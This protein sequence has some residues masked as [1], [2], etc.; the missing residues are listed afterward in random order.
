M[1]LAFKDENDYNWVVRKICVIGPGI[2][3]M[4]MAALLANARI[5]QGSDSP[6]KVLVLQRASRTSG[7]KVDAINSGKSVIGGVEPGLDAIVANCVKEGLLSATSNPVDAADSDVVLVCVQTD[8]K[9][10]EPDYG[11]LFDAL[12]HLAGALQKRPAGNIPVI[13]FESTLAPSTMESVIRPF[14]AERGLVE[15]KDIL[16][17]NSPNRVMPG[18]LVERVASA[19][20]LV[21]GLHPLTAKLVA[22]LYSHIVTKGTL[23]QTNSMTA[24]VVKTLENAYRDVRIAFASEIVR[25]C[26][27]NDIDFFAVRDAV[28]ER[29]QQTDAASKDATAVPVGG[30]LVPLVGVGGHC[31]PKDGILLWWRKIESKADTGRSLILE[32]RKINDAAPAETIAL[33]ERAFGPVD[34]KRVALLGTAYRFDSEDTRNSPTLYLARLLLDRGC[35]LTIHDPYVKK[36]DQNLERFGLVEYFTNDLGAAVKDAELVFF[37]TGHAVYKNDLEGILAKAPKL[38]G[39]VDGANLYRREQF[40]GKSVGY[41]GIGRGTKAPSSELV[42]FVEESF[43]TVEYGVANEV[44]AL[45]EFLN[46]SYARDQYNKVDFERVRELASTCATGC[47]IVPTRKGLKAPSI[48]GYSSH[49]AQCAASAG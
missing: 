18:R 24:E 43:R 31:L 14:F 8:K 33:G 34:G 25:Y 6:A 16:L 9:G 11:P 5:K 41:T 13:V 3:G 44:A 22:K 46:G 1:P 10:F 45:A 4:P 40:A 30:V 28:N 49:L 42:K 35:T 15:G 32:S 7:W 23:H 39:V 17:G 12:E 37:C 21:A 19:D 27:K 47:A 36:D 48:D 2:V 29:L 26:D 20:K 38:K